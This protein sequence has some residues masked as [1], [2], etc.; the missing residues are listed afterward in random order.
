MHVPVKPGF[1]IRNRNDKSGFKGFGCLPDKMNFN[2]Q[3]P[4]R[5]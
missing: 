1:V 2:I 3:I 5:D 4:L